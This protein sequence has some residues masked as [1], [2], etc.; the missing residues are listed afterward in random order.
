MEAF[1]VRK[2]KVLL[3]TLTVGLVANISMAAGPAELVVMPLQAAS[4]KISQIFKISD[5]EAMTIANTIIKGTELSLG[6]SIP[7]NQLE[8]QRLLDAPGNE[9]LKR[10]F[11]AINVERLEDISPA[12]IGRLSNEIGA[13]V[14]SS[15]RAADVCRTCGIT[16]DLF[17]RFG[18]RI[19]I[20]LEVETSMAVLRNTPND[21]PTLLRDLDQFNRRGTIKGASTSNLR[22][23][24]TLEDE[25]QRLTRHDLR[26]LHFALSSL[27]GSNGPE[28][29]A[30]AEVY[31]AMANGN[32]VNENRLAMTIA[33]FVDEGAEGKATLAELAEI[34]RKINTEH[35]TPKARRDS[36]CKHF[37]DVARGN[38][39]REASFRR[40]Q[41]CP[42]YQLVFTA[43]SL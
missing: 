43:C 2:L 39:A 14:D 24:M 29:K 1:F 32:V 13:I 18:M 36:L 21:I 5:E 12:D 10:A 41:R 23:Y 27:N 40:L 9:R 16:E 26:K 42:N 7:T 38:P 34:G 4:K 30:A 35:S 33:D 37:A 8:L 6:R 19:Y 3:S 22:R 25:S 20:P 28:A 11:A 31:I 17:H 15:R